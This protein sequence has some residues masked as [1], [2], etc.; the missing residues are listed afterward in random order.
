MHS[1]SLPIISKNKIITRV[2]CFFWL[3]A[4]AISWKVW[5]ADRIFP[6]TPPFNF[7]FVPSSIHLT[8][9]ILS[10]SAIFFLLLFPSNRRLQGS[11]IILEILSCLLDQ[12]RWQ[13]WEY[14]YMFIILALLINYKNE[15][16]AAS[17]ISFILI[18]IYF[19]S[20]I[21]KMNPAFSQF[22]RQKIIL[23]EIF[24][25]DDSWLSQWLLFHTGYLLG[26]IETLLSIGLLFKR[27]TRISGVFLIIMHL[28]ILIVFGPWGMNYDR[29]IWPWNIAM[30]FIVYVYFIKDPTFLFSFPPMWKGGNKLILLAFGAL[31]I[32]NFFGY[33][34]FFLS[35][36][37]FSSKTPDIYICIRNPENCKAL[38]PF[39]SHYKRTSICDSNSALIDVREWSFKEIQIPAYPEIRVYKNIQAQLIKR[40]PGM[41]ATFIMYQYINGRKEIIE[42]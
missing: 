1:A 14:Q 26:L 36:S 15:K 10:L 8:L 13:P 4:K 3:V 18:A 11:V 21:S 16:N 23:S 37:L 6:V 9:F 5:L 22:V 42:R 20:G 41:N 33:W 40:Y 19:F 12:N 28:I 39:I 27:S 34:D 2:I 38:Q 35:S 32:L 29:I 30:I 31:P 25:P 24:K 7:L 17:T